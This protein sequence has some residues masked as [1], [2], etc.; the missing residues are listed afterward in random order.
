ML[1]SGCSF[2]TKTLNVEEAGALAILI[3]DN[4]YANDHSYIDMIQDDTNREP[5]IP[6]LF[7]LGKDG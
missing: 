1:F 2:V 5:S 4:D 7:M 3:T 6:S